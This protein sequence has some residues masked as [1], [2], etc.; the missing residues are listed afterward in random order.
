MS[1]IYS[2][3]MYSYPHKTAYRPV[4]R[5]LALKHL[6]ALGGSGVTPGL[7][8]SS[9]TPALDGGGVTPA[10][11]GGGA[12]R[13]LP[14]VGHTEQASAPVAR[15]G[16]QAKSADGK[17]FAEAHHAVQTAPGAWQ[18]PPAPLGL[19]LH[20]P[21]CQSKCG[22][23]NLFSVAGADEALMR[24]YLKA[25]ERQLRQ[26]S[27]AVSLTELPFSSLTLGGGTPSLLPPALLEQAFATIERFT[28]V[29]PVSVYSAMELAPAATALENTTFLRRAG[30]SRVSLGVQSFKAEELRAIGRHSSPKAALEA[31][32][33]VA[34][35]AFA[36]FNI[37]LIYGIPG[38]SPASL[39]ESIKTALAYQPD[40]I[41][42]YP[43]YARPLTPLAQSL[44][45]QHNARPNDKPGAQQGA[46]PA[47]I[48]DQAGLNDAAMLQLYRHGREVLLG[49]GYE[50]T[51]MRRFL[52]GGAGQSAADCGF[53]RNLSLGCGGRSYLGG[54]HVCEPYAVRAQDCKRLLESFC[55]KTDF[56]SGLYGYALDEDE[57]RRRYAVKNLLHARGLDLAR[58]QAIFNGRARK[59]FPFL[60]EWC[61]KGYLHEAAGSL[62][63]SPSGMERSDM[64][65]PSFI[66]KQVAR[67]SAEFYMQYQNLENEK[68]I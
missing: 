10:L 2:Q 42:L 64:L 26:L 49:A 5:E 15:R 14:D 29:T 13:K 27:E 45:Q 25:T 33:T 53:E 17:T 31:C 35:A 56:L 39:A 8:G 60:E 59:H 4:E 16:G 28:G 21:F 41:F 54:L 34:A 62:R 57:Q 67:L 24:S 7:G 6:A 19:Y 38:Q 46:M 47:A 58:Y 11:D 44:R 9:A 32:A 65:G 1:E 30:F 37:D 40:E 51:S 23:C 55:A 63:L 43:L 66:S 18:T 50:Q 22:Y 61:K 52:R 68:S 48:S 12:T 20:V 36:A 3:Y